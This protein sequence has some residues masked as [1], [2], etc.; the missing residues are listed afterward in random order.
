MTRNRILDTMH[1]LK[2]AA[3]VLLLAAFS[4]EL[5]HGDERHFT[6]GY[7]IVQLV[8]CL[9]FLLDFFVGWGLAERRGRY[10][11]RHFVVLLLAIP[12]IN[13][14]DWCG[15]R[16]SHDWAVLVGLL[17]LLLIVLATWFLL[18]GLVSIRS[19]RIFFTYLCGVLLFTYFAALVFYDLEAPYNRE[20]T[21]FSNALWWSGLN[22]STAGAPIEPMSAVGK[23]LSVLLPIAGMLFLPI[24]T[25]YIVQYNDRRHRAAEPPHPEHPGQPE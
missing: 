20:L 13:I 17:P 4:Y 16:L 10:F 6:H 1:L 21:S 18:E 15:I 11:A 14:V 12:W 3:G 23:L 19:H 25:T 9:L 8:V 22:L 7:L 24:F 2:I 5:L